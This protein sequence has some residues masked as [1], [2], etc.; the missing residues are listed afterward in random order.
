MSYNKSSTFLAKSKYDNEETP[1]KQTHQDAFTPKQEILEIIK[2]LHIKCGFLDDEHLLMLP[3]KWLNHCE[4][5]AV[6]VDIVQNLYNAYCTPTYIFVKKYFNSWDPKIQGP[7]NYIQSF[8]VAALIDKWG[9]TKHYTLA[10][11]R[12][13]I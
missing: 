8:Y 9:T 1:L 11:F 7:R 2:H 5:P 13:G 10:M 4:V 3:I 12:N 6:N